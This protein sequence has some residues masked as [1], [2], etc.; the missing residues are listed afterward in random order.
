M[1][2]EHGNHCRVLSAS[3]D[4]LDVE[5]V[6]IEDP[7]NQEVREVEGS[8]LKRYN[9]VDDGPWKGGWNKDRPW[10]RKNDSWDLQDWRE[11]RKETGTE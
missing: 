11:K 5:W 8:T 9:R 6:T 1:V 3:F 4:L 7:E 2:D 10:E